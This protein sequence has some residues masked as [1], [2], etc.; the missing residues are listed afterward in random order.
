MGSK[1]ANKVSGL[2]KMEISDIIRTRLKDPRVG[3]VTI[4]DVVL[5]D[6]LRNARVYVSVLGDETQR[7]NT[8]EGLEHACPFIQNELG[9]RLRLRYLPHLRFYY[10]ASFEYGANIDRI[11][12][13]LHLDKSVEGQ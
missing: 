8:L 2:L 5:S 4:T 10:D 13:S 1:R 9:S 11:L 7:D 12:D 3:F 6:D